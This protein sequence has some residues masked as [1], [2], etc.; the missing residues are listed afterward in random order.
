MSYKTLIED[1]LSNLLKHYEEKEK[2]APELKTQVF[3]TI[4]NI[5]LTVDMLDLFTSKYA[6][7]NVQS[8]DLLKKEDKEPQ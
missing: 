1:E 4:D 6:S 3:R 8:F 5:E 7:V 2:L